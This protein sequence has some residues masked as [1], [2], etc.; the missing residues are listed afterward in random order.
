MAIEY[1]VTAL[2]VPLLLVLGHAQCGGAAHALKICS[3]ENFTPSSFIDRWCGMAKDA[4]CHVCDNFDM[5]VRSREL[6]QELVRQS[7]HNV[8]T[9]PFVRD[10]VVGTVL[11]VQSC[12]EIA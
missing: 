11:R 5:N 2:K 12:V 3:R 8:M 4:V 10:A 1:A 6:E 7:I 9:F